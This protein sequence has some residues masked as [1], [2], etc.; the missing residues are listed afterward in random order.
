M[1]SVQKTSPDPK[2]GGHVDPSVRK[3]GKSVRTQANISG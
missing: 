2:T 1:Q 3:E